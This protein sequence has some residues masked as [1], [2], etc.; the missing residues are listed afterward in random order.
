MAKT[1]EDTV[2]DEI[3]KPKPSDDDL[4]SQLVESQTGVFPKASDIEVS[5]EYRDPYEI[6]AWCNQDDWAFAW[7]DIKDDI[8]RHRAFEIEYFQLVTR[9][10]PCIIQKK[11]NQR[12]F[13]DHGAVQRRMDFL[14][15]RPRDLDEKL[16][17]YPVLR[18]VEMA[19]VLK[20]GKAG[21]GYELSGS[22]GSDDSKIHVVA[23][24]EAGSVGVEVVDKDMFK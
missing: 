4:V 15:Y 2:L 20:D 13:R 8:A 5:Y 3:L 14:V 18:H 11:I 24:E 16:R 9:M 6:P 19:N 22:K 1:K 23:Q 12:D 17:T 7:V 21:Q 10:S